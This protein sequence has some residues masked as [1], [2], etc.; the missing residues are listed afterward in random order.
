[1]AQIRPHLHMGDAVE[2]NFPEGLP[3]KPLEKP[4][5]LV[6][7]CGEK[8]LTAQGVCSGDSPVDEASSQPS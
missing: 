5:I 2:G 7:D 1:M 4:G 3:V 6:L 8:F